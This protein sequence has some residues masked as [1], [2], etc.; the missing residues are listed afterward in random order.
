MKQ[1]SNVFIILI[2]FPALMYANQEC[3]KSYEQSH[4]FSNVVSLFSL[5]KTVPSSEKQEAGADLA[6]GKIIQF[7]SLKKDVFHTKEP[8]TYEESAT[9]NIKFLSSLVREQDLSKFRLT[10]QRVWRL[11]ANYSIVKDN[12]LFFSE[13]PEYLSKQSFEQLSEAYAKAEEF[14]SSSKLFEQIEQRGYTLVPKANEVM[15]KFLPDNV[16]TGLSTLEFHLS[17]LKINLNLVKSLDSI[18]FD[19]FRRTLL[20]GGERRRLEPSIESFFEALVGFLDQSIKA[21]DPSKYDYE[22][23]IRFVDTVDVLVNTKKFSEYHNQNLKS[24]FEKTR[25]HSENVQRLLLRYGKLRNLINNNGKNSLASIK[26]NVDS[27][28][29]ITYQH[30]EKLRSDL[31]QILRG[32]FQDSYINYEAML[33]KTLELTSLIKDPSN[34]ESSENAFLSLQATIQF[35]ERVIN[36]IPKKKPMFGISMFTREEIEQA[37]LIRDEINRLRKLFPNL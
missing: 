15:K 28:A 31:L 17:F 6:S 27:N 19:K 11:H 9:N 32:K 35:L 4:I 14:L 22:E 20:N 10:Q 25:Q 7:R 37:N 12:Y 29:T 23:V 3:I 26:L 21:Y 8:N 24:Y 33:E 18:Y 1:A 36:D 2:V 34:L 30:V 16:T 13:H 5:S